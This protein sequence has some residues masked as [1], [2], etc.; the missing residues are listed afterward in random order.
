MVN[1]VSEQDICSS[2]LEFVTEGGYPASENVAAAEFPLSALAK[3]LDLLA[4]AREQVEVS[5]GQLLSI[6]RSLNFERI[7]PYVLTH[8]IN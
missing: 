2:V 7:A 8:H 4:K 6:P 1:N 3:E 5:Y